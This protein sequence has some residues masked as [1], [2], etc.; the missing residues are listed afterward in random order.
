[1]ALEPCNR[2]EGHQVGHP[3]N[4]ISLASYYIAHVQTVIM[5]IVVVA[6]KVTVI[7]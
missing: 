4:T 2:K 5:V 3:K 6:V 7:R 1:M